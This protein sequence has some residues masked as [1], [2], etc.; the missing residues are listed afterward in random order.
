MFPRASLLILALGA[1]PAHAV[2][3][4]YSYEV[5]KT[6]PHDIHAFTE[7]LFYLNGFLY[8]ST[9]LARQSSIRKVVIEPGEVVRKVDV[10]PEYFGEG[11]VNW[12]THLFSLTWKNQVGF[13]YD[14]AT[15]KVQRLFGYSGEGWA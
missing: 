4:V 14:L 10:P 5:V 6:Y 8:E 7:G 11:I 2:V 15:F 13:V 1:L 12:E 9:G 3:P